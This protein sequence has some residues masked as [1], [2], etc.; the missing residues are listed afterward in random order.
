VSGKMAKKSMYATYLFGGGQ[1]NAFTAR[2]PKWSQIKKE[3]LAL[4]G[5][6][7]TDVIFGT[8]YDPTSSTV[9][10]KDGMGIEGCTLEYK[11][12]K[13][14]I[15]SDEYG[16]LTWFLFDP[17]QSL[18]GG[19]ETTYSLSHYIPRCRTVDLK[20]VLKAAKTYAELGER[21][22]SLYWLGWDYQGEIQVECPDSAS[23]PE[24][25]AFATK[26]LDMEQSGYIWKCLE[27]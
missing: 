21:D 3:I 23:K 16:S 8:E 18:E 24:V 25:L 20:T 1:H 14:H 12:Y 22:K 10:T 26:L 27:P 13:C 17:S 6:T 15:D 11:L 9:D 4:N 7:H 19:V 2:K 5:L